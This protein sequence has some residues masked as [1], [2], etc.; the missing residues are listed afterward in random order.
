MFTRTTWYGKTMS[1][2]IYSILNTSNSKRYI[3]QSLDL[4]KR[5]FAHFTALRHG[6]HK[7]CH[8]QAAYNHYGSQ[9]FRWSVLQVLPMATT[10]DALNAAE[11]HYIAL[12][13]SNNPKHG[14]NVESGGS[15]SPRAS[16][17]TRL[18]MQK[19]QGLRRNRL[20]RD[21]REERESP[22]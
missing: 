17:A 5:R 20:K 3:G 16:G 15:T 12:H 11:C 10:P 7:N 22:D 9:A 21:K 6:T 2:G 4:S 1:A 18:R 8:L 19:A 13:A 14:Y